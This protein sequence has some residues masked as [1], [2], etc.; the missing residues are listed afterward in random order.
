MLTDRAFAWG[1]FWGS[2][3]TGALVVLTVRWL[4]A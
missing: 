1:W 3:V 4:G 2:A